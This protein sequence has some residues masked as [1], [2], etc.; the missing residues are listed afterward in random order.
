VEHPYMPGKLA[1]RI[2]ITP[3]AATDSDIAQL[4][5]DQK[6]VRHEEAVE[7][8][9]VMLLLSL[10]GLFFFFFF[11][12]LSFSF[13]LCFFSFLFSFFFCFF[14]SII[15]TQVFL[16]SIV[17][18]FRY[19]IASRFTVRSYTE[20]PVDASG[21]TPSHPIFHENLE[22]IRFARKIVTPQIH[23]TQFPPEKLDESLP[24]G[25]PM[26]HRILHQSQS[27]ESGGPLQLPSNT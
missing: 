22:G 7:A 18:R 12:L 1:M 19:S 17:W 2:G 5:G 20:L 14:F 16:V 3:I 8:V 26:G 27:S 6:V 4:L 23:T 9:Y 24:L 25:M 13:F 21:D 10:F 15:R 11:S